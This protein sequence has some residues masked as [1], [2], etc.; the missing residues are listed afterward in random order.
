MSGCWESNPVYLLPKQA[1]Y[2]YTT[3]RVRAS[4][5]RMRTDAMLPLCF[6]RESENIAMGMQDAHE[7]DVIIVLKVEEKVWEIP[8]WVC[9]QSFHIQFHGEMGRADRGHFLYA[10]SCPFDFM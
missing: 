2:R 10:R 1:Y 9:A 7:I 3:A 6:E 8:K 5:M 4:Y